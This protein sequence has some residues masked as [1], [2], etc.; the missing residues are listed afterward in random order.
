M[1]TY[2]S[3]SDVSIQPHRQHSTYCWNTQKMSEW[4]KRPRA[5]KILPK[6]CSQYEAAWRISAV[7]TPRYRLQL[8]IIYTPELCEPPDR[9][10]VQGIERVLRCSSHSHRHM[11]ILTSQTKSADCDECLSGPNPVKKKSQRRKYYGARNVVLIWMCA[12]SRRL[13]EVT[14]VSFPRSSRWGLCIVYPSYITL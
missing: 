10:S 6:T 4:A 13:P 2:I 11:H 1:L 9:R 14:E 7:S 3:I 12:Y 8:D 5:C